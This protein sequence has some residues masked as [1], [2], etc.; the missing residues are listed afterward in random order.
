MRHRSRAEGLQKTVLRLKRENNAL[1]LAHNY[2]P[3][4]IQ[5]VADFVGDSLELAR[6]SASVNSYDVVVFAG[7]RFMAEVAAILSEK[8]P[9]YLPRPDTLCPLASWLTP[10]KVR[11]KR[12]EY[13]DVPVVVYVNTTAEVKAEADA[14]CTSGNAIQVIE[15]LDADTVLFGPDASLA[16]YVRR[17]SHV[18]VIDLEPLGHCYVHRRFKS[19][20]ILA[21]KRSFPDARVI[22]HPECDVDVQDIADYVCSTGSMARV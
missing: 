1:I 7:V 10:E 13:P 16:E 3:I 11:A 5:Q 9:V 22:A 6:Q 8:T 18:R 2:Q 20:D 19:E 15:S 21:L 14:I 17:R 12:T 4:E